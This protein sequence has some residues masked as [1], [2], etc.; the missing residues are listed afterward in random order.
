MHI[1]PPTLAE[2]GRATAWGALWAVALVAVE[3]LRYAEDFGDLGRWL[4][5][6]LVSWAIPVLCIMG[7]V[8]VLIAERMRSLPGLVISCLAAGTLGSVVEAAA[9]RAPLIGYARVFGYSDGREYSQIA[10][11][12]ETGF[13][14]YFIWVSLF[15]GVLLVVFYRLMA[16]T[17]L[18]RTRFHTAVVARSRLQLLLDQARTQMLQAQVAPDLVLSSILELERRCCDDPARADSLLAALTEFLRSAMSGLRERR[19]SVGAEL[20][21]AQA[22][23]ALQKECGARAACRVQDKAE[24]AASLPFPAMLMLPLLRANGGGDEILLEVVDQ[25]QGAVLKLRAATASWDADLQRRMRTEL[26]ALYGDGFEME[27][28]SDRQFE[29]AITLYRPQGECR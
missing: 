21:L 12:Q 27:D 1:R 15:Y 8:F 19:S 13:A 9:L 18:L 22:Y 14:F 20:R 17:Q 2:L 3:T 4:L 16:R 5:W 11:A 25:P 6:A 10:L 24:A 26:R 28:R 29:L 23:A 7:C